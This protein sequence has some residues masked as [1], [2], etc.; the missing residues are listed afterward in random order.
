MSIAKKTSR[1]SESLSTCQHAIASRSNQNPHG[2]LQQPCL[3]KRMIRNETTNIQPGATCVAWPLS[4]GCCNSIS[5]NSTF[6]ENPQL[7]I[8]FLVM[9]VGQGQDCQ[10]DV[11]KESLAGNQILGHE[12][13]P[14][15]ILSTRLLKR[16]LSWEA[17]SWGRRCAKSNTVNSTFEENP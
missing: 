9:R 10:L 8:R 3:A 5:V 15:A 1:L 13:G 12:D 11:C 16:I 14:R 2:S 7:G 17:D 6:A 4:S